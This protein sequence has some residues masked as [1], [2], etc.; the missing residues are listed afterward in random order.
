MAV[1][2][3]LSYHETLQRLA[4]EYFA[5][6]ERETFTTKELAIWAIQNDK[7]EPPS[8]LVLRKC[9]EDFAKAL[10]EQYITD[11]FGRPVRAKHVARITRGDRQMH[12]W[13]DIRRAP[14]VHMEVAFQQRREQIVGDC[15]QLKRDMDYYNLHNP[16]VAAIQM[17][18][19]FTDDVD[20]SQFSGE[21]PPRKPR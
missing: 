5:E 8:D 20:E 15:C 10:R 18:F 9:R 17:V 16:G 19:D 11:E 3:S 2:M 14:R 13:A 4:D 7:W 21:Y 1:N 12:L 6:S